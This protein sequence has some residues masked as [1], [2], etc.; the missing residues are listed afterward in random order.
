MSVTPESAMRVT[1]FYRGV[2]ILAQTYASLPLDVVRWQTD[3]GKKSDP[4]HPLWWVIVKRPNR[5]QTSFEWR[6]GMA[7]DFAIHARCYSEIISSGGA[8]ISELI[9]LRPERVRPFRAPD[10]DIAFEYTPVSGP[11]RIILRSEMHYMHGMTLDDD[12]ITPLSPI[13]KA[14]REA[15]GLAMA[16]QEHSARLFSNGTRLGGVLKFP[17]G[18]SLKDDTAR[19]RLLAGWNRAFGGAANTGKTALLE[20]GLEWQQLGMTSEDAQLLETMKFSIADIARI[21]GIPLHK[22]AEL[23]R[24]TN[25]NI[26]H[27]GIEFVTDTVR[28]GVIR[29]EEAMERDL[30]FGRSSKTHGIVFDLD[31]LMRGDS[32]ARSEY[33]SKLRAGGIATGNDARVGEGMNRSD[34]PNMDKYLVQVNMTTIDK[35]G[36]D[37]PKPAAQEPLAATENP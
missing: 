28:P 6:E 35:I 7:A 23:D 5:W 12:G 11:A 19:A 2:S 30:L 15:L 3:G 20:D 18:K 27:Q 21:L 10:G 29:R 16:T 33:W 13:Q 9:P 24:S 37:A 14:G 34:E 1:A 17:A 22:L 32:K 26:E 4:T 31:G 8:A 36:M 25:N